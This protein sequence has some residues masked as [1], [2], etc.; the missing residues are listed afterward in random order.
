MGS[1]NANGF[2]V[3]GTDTG[4]GKTLVTAA[5]A[6]R[7]REEG[8]RVCVMKPVATGA[9]R[10][11]EQ[12][13]SDDTRILADATGETELSHVTP[14]TFEAPAAPSVA[15]RL[16]N[17]RLSLAQ[18]AAA[19]ERRREPEGFLLVEG[20]GGLLC[21]LTDDATVA[22]LAATLGLPL[23]IVAHG[24]LGTLNH[25]LLSL[26]VARGRGLAVAG[27][28]VSHREPPTGVAGATNAAELRRF[29]VPVV[30]ELPYHP[31]PAA[32]DWPQLAMLA[33]VG[34]EAHDLSQASW[35]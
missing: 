26:E 16:A 29:G 7:L 25:T 28:V 24:G 23:L 19:I 34:R 5:L 11:G 4:V 21:P 22:D 2:F 15:A 32:H 31:D 12:W 33:S 10:A 6:R 18:I 9:E 27:V 13:V 30:A 3:T 20:V 8:R 14:W 1:G 35:G 17:V